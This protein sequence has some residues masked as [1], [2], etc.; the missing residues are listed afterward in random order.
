MSPK[1]KHVILA[2]SI[3]AANFGKL[4]QEIKDAESAGADWIHCDIMDGHYIPNL[5]FGPIIVRL[6]KKITSLPLDVHLMIT[7]PEQSLEWYINAG[8][9]WVTVHP[10]TCQHLDRA[11]GRIHELGA[12]AGVVLNPGSPL[13]LVEPVINVV[14]LIL[15]MSVNPGFGGQK[16]ISNA[17]HRLQEARKIINKSGRDI[18]LSV[19]GGITP[20]NAPLVISAGADVLV[21]GTSVFEDGPKTTIPKFKKVFGD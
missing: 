19:D 2:P 3:L 8:A 6:L 12:K 9:D 18:C 1:H 10:E 21:A 7:N 5:T 11:L 20:E 16:F 17:V 13:Y 4:T 14:D 15:I